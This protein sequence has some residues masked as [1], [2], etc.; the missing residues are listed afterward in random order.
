VKVVSKYLKENEE[1]LSKITWREQQYAKAFEASL[2]LD[3]PKFQCILCDILV[4]HPT[5]VIAHSFLLG[6]CI[7]TGS[8]EMLRDG[9]GRCLP[10]LDA[11]SKFYPYVL[12]FY[13]FGLEETN[14][15]DEAADLSYKCLSIE[16]KSPWATHTFTHVVEESRDP[17]EGVDLLVRTRGDWE[18]SGLGLHILWHLALHYLDMGQYDKILKEYDTV[19]LPGLTSENAFGLVDASSLLWRLELAGHSPGEDRWRAVVDCFKEMWD[20]RGSP[21]LDLHMMLSFAHGKVTQCAARTA[22]ADQLMKS[23]HDHVSESEGNYISELMQKVGAPVCQ[24]VLAFGREQYDEVLSLLVP[25]RYKIIN[26]G[27]SWAQRQVVTVTVIKAAI[28]AKRYKLALALI[29]EIKAMKP[30]T[31]SLQVLFDD[32]KKKAIDSGQYPTT[33]S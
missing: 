15:R 32:V 25:L 5:D 26:L 28:D 33:S 27:G 8:Y 4:H 20:S 18:N 17:Q 6:L 19:M 1:L 3:L 16:P 12:S 13:A 9:I 23:L 11:S 7:F 30:K 21:F 29:A 22:L 10:F 24:A 14:F 2:K 31:R